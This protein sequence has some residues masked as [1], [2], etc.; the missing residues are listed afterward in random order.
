MERSII[1]PCLR[2]V[3]LSRSS[4]A[5]VIVMTA[6]GDLAINIKKAEP[7]GSA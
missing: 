3:T 5:S 1:P 6:Y 7:K 4:Q 2:A